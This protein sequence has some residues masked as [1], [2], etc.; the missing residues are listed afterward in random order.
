MKRDAAIGRAH[1]FFTSGAFFDRLAEWVAKDTGS[2]SKDRKP[3]LL[4]YLEEM[5]IPCID[6]MGGSCRIVEYPE[7]PCAPF[8]IGR[9]VEDDTLPT[10]LIYGHGD[11][12][13]QMREK[14]KYN[15][16]SLALTRAEDA[17]GNEIWYGRGAADN[18]GQHCLNLAAVESVLA[19][20]GYLGPAAF[21][22]AIRAHLDHAG[23][24]RVRITEV[25]NNYGLATRMDPDNP[26]VTFATASFEKTLRALDQAGLP[27]RF[28]PNL[29]GTLPNDAFS[30]ILGLPTI[31]VPHS[32][33]GCSQHA[34][35][36]HVRADIMAQ[37][38]K[39]MTGL[40]WD[41]AEAGV[42]E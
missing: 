9:R 36:E 26:W 10:V 30:H 15:L 4:S 5:I 25:E 3:E 20:R 21:I 18:K 41:M 1:T 17:E 2:R 38:L 35:N 23:F 11:T 27:V 19:E 34:P 7:E 13:P 33:G 39:L 8:L 32:F 40:F 42:P 14:W 31:W 6:R 16:D 29:G 28:L 12:V 37:G 24:E 22:P